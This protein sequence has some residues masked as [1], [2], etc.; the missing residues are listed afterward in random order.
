MA[1]RDYNSAIELMP[2]IIH[3]E[4]IEMDDHYGRESNMRKQYHTAVAS[5][6]HERLSCD[7]ASKSFNEDEKHSKSE[8]LHRSLNSSYDHSERSPV[9]NCHSN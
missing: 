9:Q 2:H 4:A 7:V 1:Q 6:G 8:Y 5:D 3:E